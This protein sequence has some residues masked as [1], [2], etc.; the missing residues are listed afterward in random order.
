MHMREKWL[1]RARV[2]SRNVPE[3]ALCH[4]V[5]QCDHWQHNQCVVSTEL[6]ANAGL[7]LSTINYFKYLARM[8]AAQ[9]AC[10]SLTL[11]R[12]VMVTRL[13]GPPETL[14]ALTAINKATQSVA[15]APTAQ[16][17]G[18]RGGL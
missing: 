11:A 7:I 2:M 12:R 15:D 8:F 14:Q 4:D 18:S 6:D 5:G 16:P 10:A 1:Q 9:T 17:D 13:R 3:L